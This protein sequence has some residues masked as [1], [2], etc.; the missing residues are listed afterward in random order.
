MSLNQAP[1]YAPPPGP[2]P[3]HPYYASNMTQY[4]HHHHHQHPPPPSLYPQ[5]GPAMV[6]QPHA[7]PPYATAL[8]YNQYGHLPSPTLH[9]EPKLVPQ[10]SALTRQPQAA[11]RSVSRPYGD[12]YPVHPSKAY[13][14]GSSLTI[15]HASRPTPADVIEISDSE[16]EQTAPP[17]RRPGIQ[18]QGSGYSGKDRVR[19]LEKIA[20]WAGS[21]TGTPTVQDDSSSTVPTTSAVSSRKL[22]RRPTLDSTISTA[23]AAL[24]AGRVESVRK[25][26]GKGKGV[27]KVSAQQSR[28]TSV[29]QDT[30]PTQGQ[31]VPKQPAAT[32]RRAQPKAAK[33]RSTPAKLPQLP[34]KVLPM[35]QHAAA[36]T[37]SAKRTVRPSETSKPIPSSTESAPSFKQPSHLGVVLSL[38]TVAS[39]NGPVIGLNATA[40]RVPVAP[41]TSSTR[42]R[43]ASTDA[44]DKLEPVKRARNENVAPALL[45][46]A[47]VPASPTKDRSKESDYE[48]EDLFDEWGDE[49]EDD[50]LFASMEKMPASSATPIATA[51]PAASVPAKAA[52]P[53]GDHW[54]NTSTIGASTPVH[55]EL[56]TAGDPGHFPSFDGS[57]LAD[58]DGMVSSLFPLKPTA[59][60]L[61][62]L[63]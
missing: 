52:T 9:G 46:V 1:N 38:P 20:G 8:Q 58:A 56:V 28:S 31:P 17:E 16:D 24:S 34:T 63:F 22:T 50:D 39:G 21:R 44:G 40:P 59:F 33:S 43:R 55:E 35:S 12:Q 41:V 42:K 36:P 2:P 45:P 23:D 11:P 13:G 57:G 37:T 5:A 32:K 60:E 25:E 62:P 30:A 3:R 15:P 51:C 53:A 7:R 47:S 26:E 6:A 29:S 4:H 54:D 27:K 19:C 49:E 18:R 14:A 48:S 61:A 10:L